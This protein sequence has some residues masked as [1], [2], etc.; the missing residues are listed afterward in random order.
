MRARVGVARIKVRVRVRVMRVM[1]GRDEVVVASVSIRT[2]I[3]DTLTRADATTTCS[4][5]LVVLPPKPTLRPS[6]V[7]PSAT[8]TEQTSAVH[9]TAGP[10]P[11]DSANDFDASSSSHAG[12]PPHRLSSETVV[13]S[14][15]PVMVAFAQLRIAHGLEQVPPVPS[16]FA[17][18]GAHAE[19]SATGMLCCGQSEQR[20]CTAK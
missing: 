3:G 4:E 15:V 7:V 17:G 18:H 13:R 20:P 19:R 14:P 5:Q 2:I 10:E 12:Y 16:R 8:S 1:E 6:A 9:G 11:S